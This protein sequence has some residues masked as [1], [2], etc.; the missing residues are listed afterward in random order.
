MKNIIVLLAFVLAYQDMLAQ[1][2]P[3]HSTATTGSTIPVELPSP[4][5]TNSLYNYERTF[6]PQN[7]ETNANAINENASAISCQMAT[8]YYDGSNRHIQTIKRFGSGLNGDLV[9]PIDN[10]LSHQYIEFLPY[11]V[12]GNS[13]F[14]SSPYTAQ[15]TFYENAFPN[16]E[17][18]SYLLKKFGYGAVDNSREYS[19]YTPGKAT[20]GQQRGNT[21]SYGL[22]VANEI[23]KWRLDLSQYIPSNIGYYDAGQL[24]KEISV[25]PEGSRVEKFKD[26]GDRLI[27]MKQYSGTNSNPTIQT[28]YLVYDDLGREVISISPNAFLALENG[29]APVLDIVRQGCNTAEF[30]AQGRV[31][32]KHIAGRNGHDYIIYDSKG[33]P[34]LIQSPNQAIGNKWSFIQYD[35][36]D[37]PVRTGIFINQQHYN[38]TTIQDWLDNMQSSP[39][40]NNNTSLLYFLGNPSA[41][42]ATITTAIDA[43]VWVENYYDDYTNPAIVA[44]SYDNSKFF[45]QLVGGGNSYNPADRQNLNPYGKLTGRRVKVL[46]SSSS[47]L[48]DWLKEVYFYDTYGR[49]IQVQSNNAFGGWDYLSSQYDYNGRILRTVVYHNNPTDPAKPFTTIA[50]A[51]NYATITFQPISILQQIDN[52]NWLTLS[53]NTYNNLNQLVSKRIGQIETQ[54]Y[55]YNLRGQLTGI[56]KD[57]AET[58]VPVSGKTFGQSIKYEHGFSSKLYGGN[59]SGIIWKGANSMPQRAYGYSYDLSG[60]LIKADFAEYTRRTI[61]VPITYWTNQFVD[62]SVSNITYDPNGNIKS[63]DARGQ[64]I[65]QPIDVD[66][67]SYDYSSTAGGNQLSTVTDAVTTSFLGNDFKDGNTSGPDYTYDDNGN[68]KKDA[69]K[70][71]DSIAYNELDLPREVIFGGAGSGNIKYVYD[72]LGNKLSEEIVTSASTSVKN[73]IGP[74]VYKGN[75]LDYVLHPEGKAR[76]HDNV[77]G[78]KVFDYDFFIKDHQGNIRTIVTAQEVPL[79]EY[80]ATHELASANFEREVFSGIDEVRETKP[81]S[82]NAGD[83]EAAEL[84]GTDPERRI[85]TSLLL[86]VMA[87]D[88]FDLAADGYYQS[89]TP[90]DDQVINN[91]ELMESLINALS[92]GIT[93]IEG[94]EGSGQGGELIHNLFAPES[95]AN[96]FFE[97]VNSVT[98]PSKPKA[99]LNY[100]V[101]DEQMQLVPEESGALQIGTDN[102]WETIHTAGQVTIGR[103][104]YLAVFISNSSSLSTFFDNLS[105]KFYRGVLLDENHYYPYGLAINDG[106]TNALERKYLYQGKEFRSELDLNLYDFQARQYDPQIG[107]FLS[108]DPEGQFHSGYTGMGNNPV[109]GIDPD[110]RFWHIVIGA[111]VGAVINTATHWNQISGPAGIQWDKFA[112]AAL[113]GA[114]AGGVTAA[115]GGAA[116]TAA[117]GSQSAVAIG[118]GQY[119]AASA[120]SGGIGYTTGTM[121]QSTGNAVAFGDPMP[122]A[123]ETAIGMMTSMAI[124]ALISGSEAII[125]R[126]PWMPPQVADKSIAYTY[127][128]NMSQPQPAADQY[129]ANNAGKTQMSEVVVR[130]QA[131]TSN[132][133]VTIGLGLYD[134][135]PLLRGTGAI[136]YKNA[137]W[138]E[139]KLTKVDWGRASFDNDYFKQSFYEAADNATAIRFE[140]SSF[141]PFYHKPNITNFEFDHILKTPALL[142]KTTFIQNGNQ[143]FWNGSGFVK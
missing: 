101:F 59:I 16:E 107:R 53:S 85:G 47:T 118:A 114:A 94:W 72:A 105:V 9:Q 70:H 24:V 51:Y 60:R 21:Q 108:I 7:F 61:P 27:C 19:N 132:S 134:D 11:P 128:S 136:T 98:D 6:L 87:G 64:L 141:N 140:V 4:F 25:S 110:G 76:Y 28:S 109:I 89:Y 126:I 56:N 111:V 3:D 73:Y 68:L 74:F 122:T 34:V 104:G 49:V 65:G 40:G 96:A 63:M 12:T 71:I 133:G 13:R 139:A 115:T 31:F 14:Q 130:A 55:Q 38:L 33:R 75:K 2:I 80:L 137:G 46:K 127:T 57:Y 103:N 84:I 42:G 90:E 88:K 93:G 112:E 92:G 124:P 35:K 83:Q 20:V 67:L 117:M 36:L 79:N 102:I 116:M 78:I 113:I 66:K 120:V 18:T 48:G 129:F 23:I 26:K 8:N 121:I 1:N 77:N 50:T 62:Y 82:T 39:L 91:G 99:F 131:S 44:R 138:Q 119:I 41:E 37:R 22:N 52:G 125:K 81:A 58:G 45:G 142:Q 32:K 106:S 123:K 15:R 5:P 143:V 86:K 97:M 100:V 69:N 43:E 30:D 10:G 54:D 29:T 95:Y 135:L 17:G